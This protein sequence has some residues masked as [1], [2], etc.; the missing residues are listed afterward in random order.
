MLRRFAG[1]KLG[2]LEVLNKLV[3]TLNKEKVWIFHGD[4]FDVTMQHA[5]WL[6]KLGATGYDLLILINRVVN[7]LLLALG[8]E[9]ISLSKRIKNGV[10]SA[11]KYISNF[12]NLTAV[13]AIEN[14]YKRV[15]SGHIHQPEIR[16]IKNEK[17][18][19]IYMN[20]GDWVENLAALE[21]NDG[22]WSLCKY[23]EEFAKTDMAKDESPDLNPKE[24]FHQ[25][26][27]EFRIVQA[28]S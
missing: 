22:C 23:N 9:R 12:E 26:V 6:T 13:L 21:Y 4:V 3:L 20:S 15:I 17:G 28:V 10:K 27:S 8:R 19:V 2:E 5:R 24:L 18:S 14:S 1:L 25:L 16:K 11:V 7:Q